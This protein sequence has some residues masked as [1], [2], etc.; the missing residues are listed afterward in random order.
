MNTNSAPYLAP[1][2]EIISIALESGFANSGSNFNPGNFGP[3][4]E[5]WLNNF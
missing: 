4:H 2:V 5:D 3:G 1:A